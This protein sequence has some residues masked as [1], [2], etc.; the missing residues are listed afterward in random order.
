VRGLNHSLRV[1]VARSEEWSSRFENCVVT[2]LQCALRAH[3]CTPC[4]SHVFGSCCRH[5]LKS[6]DCQTQ[7]QA[8]VCDMRRGAL[9][10]MRI[11]VCSARL[12]R[13]SR[14]KLHA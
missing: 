13:L 11:L 14:Q 9:Q 2:W 4:P 3:H 8:Q 1:G 6:M 7:S 12:K 5:V 10:A